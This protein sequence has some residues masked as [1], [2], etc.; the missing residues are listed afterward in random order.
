MSLKRSCHCCHSLRALGSRSRSSSNILRKR[1]WRLSH[2]GLLLRCPLGV[3]EEPKRQV[4]AASFFG[5][6][7]SSLRKKH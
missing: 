7:S 4:A 1:W 6:S 2:H 5:T 3:V